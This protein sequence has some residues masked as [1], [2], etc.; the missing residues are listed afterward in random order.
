MSSQQDAIERIDK[1]IKQLDQRDIILEPEKLGKRYGYYRKTK[2]FFGQKDEYMGS[3]A[4]ML[5]KHLAT[6]QQTKD[7]S[8]SY[9][10]TLAINDA[11]YWVNL[12]YTSNI[13]K[14]SDGIHRKYDDAQ[15]QIT[16]LTREK[17]EMKEEIQ[18]MSADLL[19]SEAERR[20]LKRQLNEERIRN[21][22]HN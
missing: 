11:L 20:S 14:S 4:E 13:V 8:D 9:L 17:K 1:F 7:A 22:K 15:D 19:E 6:Y 5:S 12:A 16:N 10:R 21:E 18:Q 2:N 3:F